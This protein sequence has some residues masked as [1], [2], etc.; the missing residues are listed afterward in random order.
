MRLLLLL[1]LLLPAVLGALERLAA[2]RSELIDPVWI[3]RGAVASVDHA[4]WGAFL[5]RYL[6]ADPAG[7][8]LLDYA[9]VTAEDRAALDAYLDRL[10]GIDPAT[11]ARDA[12]TAYWINLYN[13]GTVALILDHYPVESIRDIGGGL[14]EDGPWD[15]PLFTVKGRRLTLNDVEHGIL[16]PVHDEPRIH[17]AVNCAALGCPDLAPEPWRAAGLEDRLAA[18]E[19]AFVDDPRGVRLEDGALVLSKIWLWFR[20][21]FAD[22]EAALLER[23]RRVAGPEAAAAL[24]GR[25]GADAYAYDW[26]LNAP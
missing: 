3:E 21:D 18:A 15:R 26:R 8:N 16:R 6:S 11:L 4:A 10:Q 17:Y 25:D 7:P 13:A 5:D 20:E 9:A 14:F 24:E 2:P 12:Q 23:L 22:S 1:P 19:R